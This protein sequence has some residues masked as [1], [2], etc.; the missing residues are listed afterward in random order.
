MDF[1]HWNKSPIGT[2]RVGINLCVDPTRVDSTR[3]VPTRVDPT[4]QPQIK[5]LTLYL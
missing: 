3:V 4:T 1:S 5:F 2:T